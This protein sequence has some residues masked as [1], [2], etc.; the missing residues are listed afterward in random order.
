MQKSKQSKGKEKER[1]ILKER[2]R[3]STQIEIERKS[4]RDRMRDRESRVNKTKQKTCRRKC[5][6]RFQI[7]QS[8][9]KFAAYGVLGV[10]VMCKHVALS[11]LL[12]LPT[13]TP[14]CNGTAAVAC[15]LM[16]LCIFH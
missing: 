6:L 4:E 8:L 3:E 13:A 9:T 14:R 1:V 11:L 10:C 12:S 7:R 2:E 5:N 16:A 15:C